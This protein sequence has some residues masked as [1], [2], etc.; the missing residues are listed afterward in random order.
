MK[1]Y[2]NLFNK[3]VDI[4]NLYDAYRK[5][6]RN[7]S[8][9]RDVIMFEQNRDELLKQLQQK[10]I[11]GGY[12]TS[13]YHT[14]TIYEPKERLIYRL[15]F[16]PDRI[17]HHA[18]MNILE[19]IWVSV[20]INNTYSCIKKRGIH[21]A[22]KDVRAAMKDRQNT[23]Y[24]LKL[25]VKKFYPS[26][27]HDILKV[28]IRKKIKDKKLLQLLD[29]II[30]STDGVPIG[31]YLSQFFAN[32]YVSYF[33]HYL[34]EVKK[35]KYYFRYADDMVIL[36]G[37]KKFLHSLYNDIRQY[38]NDNLKLSVKSDYQIFNVEDR[39]LS[40]VGYVIRHDYVLLRKSIKKNLF[41]KFS[42]LSKHKCLDKKTVKKEFSSY[43]G[44]MKYCNSKKLMSKIKSYYFQNEYN[45]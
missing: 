30:D 37:D 5:A 28:V 11:N 45:W 27:N 32:L 15:P 16:Y 44:W 10:L 25:D 14:F 23:K 21:K 3:I 22:L 26:I 20:F 35:V 18:I 33:D 31:N 41:K 8:H 7:K 4:D 2:N 9:R 36:H 13:K 34:K 24:C 1:R 6:K 40:F 17:V 39:G 38:L 12:R 42:K 29:E 19:P 43:F